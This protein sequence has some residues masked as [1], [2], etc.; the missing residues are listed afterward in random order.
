MPVTWEWEKKKG[1]VV[2][3]NKNHPEETF[4]WNIYQ[5]NCLGAFI[6]EYTDRKEGPMYQFMCFFSDVHH[7]KRMLGLEKCRD[8]NKSNLLKDWY[9]DYELDHIKLDTNY[10]DVEKLTRYFTQAG[11]EVRL[12]KG[13]HYE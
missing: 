9:M 6:Y 13:A 12:F 3:K 10:P 11:F 4:K 7:M 2:F 8:G 1:E 5:A